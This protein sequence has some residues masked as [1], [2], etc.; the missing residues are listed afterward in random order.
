MHIVVENDS[1]S[2]WHSAAMC[3]QCGG[4]DLVRNL[5]T[6]PLP[7]DRE[8]RRRLLLRIGSMAYSAGR[9]GLLCYLES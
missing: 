5:I 6:Q 7:I 2:D 8:R 4:S 9:L 3:A 1:E